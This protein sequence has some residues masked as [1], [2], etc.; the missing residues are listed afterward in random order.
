[1]S[2]S[3]L[4][5]KILDTG[6]VFFFFL[7]Q[8]IDW[9][10]PWK[11]HLQVSFCCQHSVKC[12][13]VSVAANACSSFQIIIHALEWYSRNMTDVEWPYAQSSRGDGTNTNFIDFQIPLLN[14]FRWSAYKQLKWPKQN[15]ET[16]HGLKWKFKNNCMLY[17]FSF[18]SQRIGQIPRF[19][20]ESS[21][22]GLLQDH[23]PLYFCK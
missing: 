23:L 17:Y 19:S 1:M 2:F 5:Y 22:C 3:F 4:Q 18:E 15:K 7:W 13:L 21:Q 10:L 9:T 14:Q 12:S 11:H 8:Q 16:Q 6:D 20:T